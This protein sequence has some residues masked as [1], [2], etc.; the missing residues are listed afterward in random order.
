MFVEVRKGYMWTPSHGFQK[1][2]AFE[3][4]ISKKNDINAEVIFSNKEAGLGLNKHLGKTGLSLG[5]GVASD[6]LKW[7]PEVYASITKEWKF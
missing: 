1:A 6:Y 4:N 5:V 2:K 3:Y 7:K